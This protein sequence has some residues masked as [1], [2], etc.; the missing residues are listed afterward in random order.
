MDGPRAATPDDR[1]SEVLQGIHV[2]TDPR[3]A[4]MHA[5][6]ARTLPEMRMP[7]AMS[8]L[9][10]TQTTSQPCTALERSHGGACM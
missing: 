7:S 10:V 3:L 1:V 5:T 4:C 2:H 6:G 8:S 9:G